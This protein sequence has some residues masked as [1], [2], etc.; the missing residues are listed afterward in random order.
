MAT[1]NILQNILFCVQQNIKICNKLRGS[2]L[3]LFLGK[4]YLQ[5]QEETPFEIESD[6]LYSCNRI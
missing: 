2:K 4:L 5:Y 3:F 1:I 6:V